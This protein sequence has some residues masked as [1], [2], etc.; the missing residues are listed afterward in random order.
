[1]KRRDGKIAKT[2][3]GQLR[4][5]YRT[6]PAPRLRV[7]QM[8]EWRLAGRAGASLGVRYVG[9]C[10]CAVV[11]L[12]RHPLTTTNRS[13]KSTMRTPDSARVRGS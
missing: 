13:F 8:N 9:A 7:E 4:N 5:R 12:I 3:L 10:G 2:F 1:M 11:R 6:A